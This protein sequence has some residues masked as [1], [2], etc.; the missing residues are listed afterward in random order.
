MDGQLTIGEVAEAVGL[1]TSAVRY[2]ERVGVLPPAERVSGQRRYGPD[3]IPRL[4]TVQ[5]GQQAG[6]SLDEIKQLL[7]GA[8]DGHAAEELRQLAERKLPD[9]DALI[10]RAQAMK[11]WLELAAECR[12][13]SLDV[14]ALFADAREGWQTGLEPATA[15]TTSRSSTN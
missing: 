8:D 15:G 6:F 10:E 4:R 11:S 14:C 5:A 2:Y 1:N 9:I 3:T 12:C 13:G 7:R